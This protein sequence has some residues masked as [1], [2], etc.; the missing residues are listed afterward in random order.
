MYRMR[1]SAWPPFWGMFIGIHNI[2]EPY[3][4]EKGSLMH[5]YDA[6]QQG[7][8]ALYMCFQQAKAKK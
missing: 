2:I 4:L 8:M 5:F 6:L 7:Y 3:A 1:L